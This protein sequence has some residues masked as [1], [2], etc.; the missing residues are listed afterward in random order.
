MDTVNCIGNSEHRAN[1]YVFKI[2]SYNRPLWKA[3]F[4]SNDRMMFF[5]KFRK[6]MVT[7]AAFN[8]IQ[9]LLLLPKC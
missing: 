4:K 5:A 3:Y 7:N 1:K 2:I 6:S 8:Y 9:W